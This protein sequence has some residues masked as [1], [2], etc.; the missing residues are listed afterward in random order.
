[1]S[2]PLRPNIHFKV[3][4]QLNKIIDSNSKICSY[5]L[6][7]GNIELSLSRAGHTVF[8]ITNKAAIFNFWTSV[9]DDPKT[10]SDYVNF[11]FHKLSIRELI[12]IFYL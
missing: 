8:G 5:F 10:L 12:I 1:M 9:L 7:D 2:S 6:Y 4:Q 11:V 3:N